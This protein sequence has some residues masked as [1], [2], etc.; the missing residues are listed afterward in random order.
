M[1]GARPAWQPLFEMQAFAIEPFE[2]R[3][4]VVLAQ[5]RRALLLELVLLERLVDD[6]L[7]VNGLLLRVVQ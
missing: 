6:A 3:E 4:E 7:D 2:Q 1:V 5:L